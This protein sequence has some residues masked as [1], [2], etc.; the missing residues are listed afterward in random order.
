MDRLYMT[1]PNWSHWMNIIRHSFLQL[2]MFVRT[3]HNSE[4]TCKT[5]SLHAKMAQCFFHEIP[6]ERDRI[7]GVHE[8]VGTAEG[9]PRPV[10]TNSPSE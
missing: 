2:Y 1:R 5:M 4:D 9:V 6:R 7:M 3:M 10:E 8:C